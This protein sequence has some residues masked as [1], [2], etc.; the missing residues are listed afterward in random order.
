MVS[1]KHGRKLV[2]CF[3]FLGLSV[4]GWGDTAGMGA[5]RGELDHLLGFCHASNSESSI[6][7]ELACLAG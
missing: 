6:P 3:A 7:A 5:V 2:F 4:G 1:G